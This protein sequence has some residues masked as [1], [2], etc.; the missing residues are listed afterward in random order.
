MCYFRTARPD[1]VVL[2]D[3]PGFHWPSPSGAH[4]A[5]VPVYYFVP[6]QL[7]AWAGWRVTKMRRWVRTVLTALPFED[8]WYRDRG[9]PTHYVGH[10]YFD[11]TRR[12][13]AR[14]GVR[15]G[16]AGEAGGP[17]VALLPGSRNQ[18]VTANF[19]LML[20]AAAKVRAARAGRAVPGRVVQRVAG[21]GPPGNCSP[22]PAC[23]PR[24]TSAARRRSSSRRTPASPCPARS[25]W[26]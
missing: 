22:A 9:V 12:A 18:E 17:V 10:P 4:R 3:Y 15:R 25:G 16:A 14:P 1:A 21:R 2:I 13:D 23:R 20:A 24:S 19:P 26:S 5:G 11:E 8:D 6:P 7:W